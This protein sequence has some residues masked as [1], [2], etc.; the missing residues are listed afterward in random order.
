MVST[1]CAGVR[2]RTNEA[3]R[4]GVEL[5]NQPSILLSI[6]PSIHSSFYPCVIPECI[7]NGRETDV[8]EN[9]AV[10]KSNDGAS[11]CT[12]VL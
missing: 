10:R 1:E 5:A 3:W 6:Y 7:T 12:E 8:T 9:G 4:D 2:E 11:N